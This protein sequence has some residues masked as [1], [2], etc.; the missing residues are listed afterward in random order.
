MNSTAGKHQVTLNIRDWTFAVYSDMN[1]NK[2]N[3]KN[4]YKEI[5]KICQQINK[6]YMVYRTTL[7]RDSGL[8][9]L[10]MGKKIRFTN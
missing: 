4:A 2:T 3:A 9:L 8:N 1:K 6:Y 10:T 7:N 5:N